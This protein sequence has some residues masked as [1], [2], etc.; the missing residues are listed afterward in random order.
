LLIV[1]DAA[2]TSREDG[3]KAEGFYV[4]T[5]SKVKKHGLIISGE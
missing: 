5:A 2:S 4:G 1:Q 3:L